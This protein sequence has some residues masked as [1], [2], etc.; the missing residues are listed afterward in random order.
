[1]GCLLGDAFRFIA[2]CTINRAEKRE[3]QRTSV[4]CPVDGSECR[5]SSRSAA[6]LYPPHSQEYCTRDGNL[7][8]LPKEAREHFHSGSGDILES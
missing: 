6:L 7:K 8:T 1:M 2:F 3:E 5:R 4:L